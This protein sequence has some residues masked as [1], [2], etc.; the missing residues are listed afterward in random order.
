MTKNFPNPFNWDFENVVP[1]CAHASL[2][3]LRN[4]QLIDTRSHFRKHVTFAL[5]DANQCAQWPCIS[6]Y[7]F[8]VACCLQSW[9]SLVYRSDVGSPRE[10]LWGTGAV[11]TTYQASGTLTTYLEGVP[12]CSRI[13]FHPWFPSDPIGSLHL[14]QEIL[15]YY[16]YVRGHSVT[17]GKFNFCFLCLKRLCEVTAGY[18]QEGVGGVGVGEWGGGGG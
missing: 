14:D 6:Y 17:L 13:Q 1:H 7:R 2:V 11:L 10:P 4:W 5:R 3:L 12:F 8:Y 9:G 18:H 16:Q 15:W